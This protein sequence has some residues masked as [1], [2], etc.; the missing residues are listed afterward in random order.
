ML[1]FMLL[2]GKSISVR[3]AAASTFTGTTTGRDILTLS[4][5]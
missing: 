5:R 2:L 1:F 4:G 3:E